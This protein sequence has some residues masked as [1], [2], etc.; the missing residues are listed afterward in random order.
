MTR[1]ALARTLSA[2]CLILM[3]GCGTSPPVRYH[4]LS[5][6]DGAG[7]PPSGSARVLVEILPVAVP[8]HLERGNLVLGDG[9]GRTS[10]L[11]TD[12][13]LAPIADDLRRIVADSLWR[14]VRATDTYDAPVSAS[15]A[16]R[17][18]YRLAIRLDRFDAVPGGTAAVT[19]SWTL[20]RLPDG[21]VHACRWAGRAPVTGP[22]P[23]AAAS[24]LATASRELADR[25]A[26]SL[27]RA[28]AGRAELCPEGGAT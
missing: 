23:A 22:D 24:A 13:W 11:E 8:E 15:A 2:L 28:V 3:A 1:P 12:R 9:R 4:A 26:T 20:N 7:A 18:L 17:P 19:G 14:T 6:P 25:I 10:V 5:T 21:R 27:E 16:G